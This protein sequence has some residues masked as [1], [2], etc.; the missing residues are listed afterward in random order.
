[1]KTAAAAGL[2]GA[3]VLLVALGIGD[4]TEAAPLATPTSCLPYEGDSPTLNA[5]QTESAQR[6]IDIGR[7]RAVPAR[8]WA[9]AIATAMQ[10]STLRM[11]DGGD[12]DSVNLY[13]QRPSQGWGTPEQIKDRDYAIN[14]F[15]GGPQPPDNP[16]LLDIP[17]WEQMPL[18]E[19]AQTVQRSAYPDAY[20][21]WTALAID[22]VRELGG[23]ELD[24]AK[25]GGGTANPAPKNPDGSWPTEGC[26]VVPDPTTS[27]GCL[28][29]RT[30]NMVN[31]AKGAG[32]NNYV[33]CWR[34]QSWGDHPEGRACDF[35]VEPDGFGGDATGPAKDYGNRLAAWGVA[36]ADTIGVK[37]VIWYR[38]IWTP[39]QGWHPYS[40]PS[41]GSNSS[42][43]HTNHVHISM[44]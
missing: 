28:T 18:T 36:N 32:Y 41:G 29:P 31:S 21:R 16:G 20:A 35:A 15:Y 26:T 5:E 40:H 43:D 6:I 13:Q 1:M 39:D 2:T 9:V 19:A 33:A 12:R 37:Y 38:Q 42:L 17:G 3:I 8:G 34:E 22:T 24:C 23:T 4:S 7:E 14:A 25:L 44:Y 10:E 27:A 11:L 30:L